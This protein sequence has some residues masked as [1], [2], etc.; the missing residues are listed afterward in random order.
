MSP[1]GT[2]TR[3]TQVPP[4]D[5]IDRSFL[6]SKEETSLQNRHVAAED[7]I[8]TKL[9]G[10]P[11]ELAGILALQTMNLRKNLSETE[12]AQ[13]GFLIAEYGPDYLSLMNQS[14]P[15]VIALDGD[16]VVGYA[17]VATQ[18]VRDGH[19]LLADLFHQI[20]QLHFK[21]EPLKG[22]NYVV[23]AQLCVA[24]EYRGI[25][26]VGRLYGHFRDSLQTHYRYTVTDIAKPNQRSLQ[27]HLKTGFQVIHSINFE[28]LE[29]N[30]VLWDWTAH[31]S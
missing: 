19:P 5:A 11:S 18:A 7:M 21:G 28:G 1:R 15:S 23:V 20:D 4:I 2:Q 17:L 16:R 12:A 25:G 8:I 22:A 31:G 6:C 29:W 26:L 30:V 24:K 3:T 10:Q 13:Q 14:Q 9:A 27:A